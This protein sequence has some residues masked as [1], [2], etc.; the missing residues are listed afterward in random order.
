M[1]PVISFRDFLENYDEIKEARNRLIDITR[2]EL[3]QAL[4][5]TAD[6]LVKKPK[7]EKKVNNIMFK[8]IDAEN[9]DNESD[10][11]IIKALK[12]L[13]KLKPGS[14]SKIYKID[15]QGTHGF[16]KLKS[17]M[18]IK[19]EDMNAGPFGGMTSRDNKHRHTW[20]VN[21]DGNGKTLRTISM[22]GLTK[23]HTHKIVD[24]Q[25]MS[26]KDEI[27]EHTHKLV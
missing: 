17:I 25:V 3:I 6:E 15:E 9:I 20:E 16:L 14:V 12:Q 5:D 4:I 1:E 13:E 21:T 11:D 23:K 2:K 27:G 18:P 26:A 7:F 8:T 10:Q 19:P 24:N 22:T